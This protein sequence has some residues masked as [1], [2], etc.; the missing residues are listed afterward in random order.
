MNNLAQMVNDVTS[1]ETEANKVMNLPEQEGENTNAAN[2]NVD[3]TEEG[4]EEGTDQEAGA[5]DLP[6]NDQNPTPETDPETVPDNITNM[7]AWARQY[8]EAIDE[9]LKILSIKIK[10]VDPDEDIVL[11]MPHPSGDILDNGEAKRKYRQFENSNQMPMI[12]L[13][14]EA[15]SFFSNTAFMIVHSTE[16]DDV[17][18]KFY[19]IS[20]R[21]AVF[22]QVVGD[23]LIPYAIRKIKKNDKNIE[24]VDPIDGLVELMATPAPT[25]N[26][27]IRYKQIEKSLGDI[28]TME[29]A[30]K[31]FAAK[32]ASIV[33]INHLLHIDN[34]IINTVNPPV[35]NG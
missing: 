5:T 4:T 13:P 35:D 19:G 29:D 9:N 2:V 25:E 15:A 23:L 21:Q 20:S 26:L 18:I 16:R 10:N 33:D 27:L 7:T 24:M 17:K 11:A 34:V 8:V 31:F 30:M 3:Q 14:G 32:Q 28:E 1:D 12:N 22:C 6:E